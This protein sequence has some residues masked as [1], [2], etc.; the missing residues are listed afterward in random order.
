M[1]ALSIFSTAWITFLKGL[2]GYEEATIS[3]TGSGNFTD[4]S[5][6]FTKVGRQVTVSI[7]TQP[8][9]ASMN[10]PSSAAGIA[11]VWARPLVQ[12]LG[13]SYVS[14]NTLERFGVDLNG[15]V[16]FGYFTGGLVDTN[17]TEAV[18]TAVLTYNV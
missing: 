11:P 14:S 1:S 9:H 16:I 5:L 3:L 4:G 18:V 12:A 17:K 2:L 6:L 15:T 10:A 13:V 7:V 8:R